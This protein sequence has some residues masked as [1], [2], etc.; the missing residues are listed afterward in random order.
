MNLKNASSTGNVTAVLQL[1]KEGAN[2]DERIRISKDITWTALCFAS[3]NGYLEIVKILLDHGANPNFADE[4]GRT[5]LHRAALMRYE[6][7]VDLLLKRGA[8]VNF[9]DANHH[10]ALHCA[11]ALLAKYSLLQILLENGAQINAQDFQGNTPLLNTVKGLVYCDREEERFIICELLI[12]WGGDVNLKDNSNKTPMD[13][14][15]PDYSRKIIE[16][17]ESYGGKRS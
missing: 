6:K 7:V 5:P 14:M 12:S 10:S 1:L 3:E 15:T 4:F 9:S 13:Y 11:T 16:L 2:V 8:N 17:F